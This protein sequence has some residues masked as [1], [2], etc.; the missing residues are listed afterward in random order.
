MHPNNEEIADIKADMRVVKDSM[1]KMSEAQTLNT[2]AQTE[3]AR[4]ISG[5]LI[6]MK[7]RDVR[8]EYLTIEVKTI[9]TRQVAFEEFSRPILT[10]AKA[11]QDFKQKIID[12]MG[13]STGKLIYV[14]LITGGLL[15]LGVDPSNWKV[16]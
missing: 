1:N 9:G 8:N 13:T 2:E 15:L 14:V 11:R 12:S 7:E 6:E 3:V 16:G 5:L 4:Q 10:K